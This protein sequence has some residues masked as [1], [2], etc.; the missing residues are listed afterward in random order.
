MSTLLGNLY[1]LYKL[2]TTGRDEDAKEY[3]KHLPL[4]QAKALRINSNFVFQVV[5]YFAR[6]Y[7]SKQTPE[8]GGVIPQALVDETFV[9]LDQQEY[10]DMAYAAVVSLRDS[11]NVL[12]AVDN[13]TSGDI[14]IA[15]DRHTDKS[16]RYQ[17]NRY[18]DLEDSLQ[19]QCY[20]IVAIYRLMPMFTGD[21][22]VDIK[23]VYQSLLNGVYRCFQ[24]GDIK[25][26]PLKSVMYDLEPISTDMVS[27]LA[28]VCAVT[29]D[30]H[31][32][33]L[34]AS[35]FEQSDYFI[36]NTSIDL[37]PCLIWNPIR[38]M[39]Y[40]AVR[41][42][43]GKLDEDDKQKV[44]DMMS[45][46]PY[47]N[48]PTNSRSIYGA[49][50]ACTLAEALAYMDND[51]RV[52]AI[53]FVKYQYESS[54]EMNPEFSGILTSLYHLIGYKTLMENMAEVTLKWAA[55]FK[56]LNRTGNVV[57]EGYDGTYPLPV[58]YRTSNDYLWQRSAYSN[59]KDESR[60]HPNV[61]YLSVVSRSLTTVY[62]PVA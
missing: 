3:S 45:I 37:H 16:T 32:T 27:G 10:L 23:G 22:L 26:H 60:D 29:R 49:V 12:S 5:S 54:N 62:Y 36:P 42:C 2:Q 61:D 4:D 57:I 38:A 9:I 59:W 7:V 25:R 35:T 11:W 48:K 43:Q 53:K 15:V 20:A 31:L 30:L 21:K 47:D 41:W 33:R 58:K 46:M 1:E 39:S 51:F 24:D 6:R 50:T 55:Q 18:G 44:L 19:W 28:L 8:L 17:D 34:V 13:D 40:A 52:P 56:G 14:F